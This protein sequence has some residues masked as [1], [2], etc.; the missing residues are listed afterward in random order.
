M[1]CVCERE[2][3]GEAPVKELEVGLG[4][5]SYLGSLDTCQGPYLQASPKDFLG[6]VAIYTDIGKSRG[7]SR[8]AFLK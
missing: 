5:I 4:F 7:G 2:T 6:Y 3:K 1:G 8:R